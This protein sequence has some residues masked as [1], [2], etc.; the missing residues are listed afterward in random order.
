MW[1]EGDFCLTYFVYFDKKH[2]YFVTNLHKKREDICIYVY[3][4]YAMTSCFLHSLYNYYSEIL[5][6]S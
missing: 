3:L 5:D 1:P 2:T 6:L 4:L